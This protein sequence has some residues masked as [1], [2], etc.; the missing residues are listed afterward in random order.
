MLHPEAEQKRKDGDRPDRVEGRIESLIQ[1]GA[2][3]DRSF[4]TPA[5]LCFVVALVGWLVGRL[6]SWQSQIQPS[7]IGN[8]PLR[9]FSERGISHGSYRHRLT[10]HR[11]QR[12][13]LI[14][15]LCGG[16]KR[17]GLGVRHTISHVMAVFAA[18]YDFRTRSHISFSRNFL[19]TTGRRFAATLGR[20][21]SQRVVRR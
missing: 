13:L 14:P 8:R 10:P 12:T 2:R 17:G 21:C 9:I 5:G 11:S 7:P 3:I 1:G 16:R 19:L 15:V 6:N 20:L 18:S 4:L